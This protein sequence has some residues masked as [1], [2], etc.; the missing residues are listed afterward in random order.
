MRDDQVLLLDML[1]A[2][3]DAISYAEYLTF[4]EFELNREKQR[5]IFNA[6]QEVGEAATQ[7][8]DEFKQNHMDIPWTKIIGTRN[9]LVHAYFDIDLESV[10]LTVQRD[11]PALVSQI[12][13][14]V[15]SSSE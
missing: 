12:K 8:S 10:W 7:L 5:A 1:E 4:T 13:P 15:P 9:H 11:L 2:S 3:C 6:I 14:L